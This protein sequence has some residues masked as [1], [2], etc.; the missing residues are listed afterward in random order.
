MKGN[1]M[2]HQLNNPTIQAAPAGS[3]LS[4]RAMLRGLGFSLWTGGKLDRKTSQEV[5]ESKGAAGDA[6]RFNKHLVPREALARVTSAVSAAK[7]THGRYTLPWTN[8]GF[9]ILPAA[10][11]MAYDSDMRRDRE[12]FESAV[13]AF[14]AVYP[15]LL[16]SAP[17][18]LGAL[19]DPTEFPTTSE[20]RGK[21]SMR[22]K[23]LP[24]PDAADFRVDMSEAQAR[25]IRAEIE[26]SAR[27][28]LDVAMRDAWQRVADVCARMVERL[29]AYKPATAKG[30]RTEGKFTDS[31]VEN[32]RDL[33]AV[34]PAFNLTN[35]PALTE[36]AGRLKV[37]LCSYQ[38]QELR[39]DSRARKVVADAAQGILDDVS[40]FLA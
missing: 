29:N 5:T 21:F 2:L 12:S 3:V 34:L 8:N 15:A 32:V 20:I 16:D 7:A 14:V 28:S 38:P 23:T 13:D 10:S 31:L 18:R 24:M 37:D 19:F 9:D 25:T 1:P 11:V 6:G 26:A 27:E 17:A 33:V 22:V 36:V 40:A 39:D 4:S 35:D 30:Q